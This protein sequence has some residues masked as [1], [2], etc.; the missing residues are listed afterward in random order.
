MIV[1]DLAEIIGTDREVGSEEIGW[2]SRRLL[3]ADEG[4]GFSLHDTIIHP[5]KPLH[6]HYK[7]HLEAVYCIEGR[8]VIKDL[9]TKKE[10][11]LKPGVV[12]ALNENDEHIL[13]AFE[14]SRFVCVFNPP[15]TGREVHDETGAYPPSDQS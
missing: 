12:Y 1:R 6:L 2:T 5:N 10:H 14:P 9:K 13:T 15:V 3:L 7:H 8:A 4:M 11:P